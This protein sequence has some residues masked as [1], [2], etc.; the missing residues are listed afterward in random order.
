MP[1]SGLLHYFPMDIH[2]MLHSESTPDEIEDVTVLTFKL[3]TTC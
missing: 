1:T 2:S 3:V